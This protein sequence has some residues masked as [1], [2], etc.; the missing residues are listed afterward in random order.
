VL[1]LAVTAVLLVSSFFMNRGE[2][3][4]SHGDV[5]GFMNNTLITFVSVWASS[6]AWSLWS[7]A[8]LLTRG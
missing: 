8:W 4:M 2:T 7:G 6:S 5:K 1:G 3:A